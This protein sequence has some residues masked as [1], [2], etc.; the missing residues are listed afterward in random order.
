[1]GKT[2]R[3]PLSLQEITRGMVMTLDEYL[4]NDTFRHFQDEILLEQACL[5]VDD[6]LKD[7]SPTP[8]AQIYAISSIIQA[9]GLPGLK[10]LAKS[11]S[12]KNTNDTNKAFWGYIRDLLE[13]ETPISLKSVIKQELLKR[14]LIQDDASI[15]DRT[16][17][18][19]IRKINKEV[20]EEVTNSVIAVYFEHFVCHYRYKIN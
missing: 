18:R 2:G 13:G 7:N 8:K 1:M 19:R 6:F 4:T 3:D 14:G 12:E 15:S 10:H 9:E 11:Q 20:T 17:Q 5:A 16:E